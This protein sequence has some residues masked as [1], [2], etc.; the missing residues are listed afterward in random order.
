MHHAELEAVLFLAGDQGI[1]EKNLQDLLDLSSETL[2]TTV[3]DYQ[4]YLQ[5]DDQRGLQLIKVNQ[6]YK[7]VTKPNMAS[8]LKKYYKKDMQVH[9]SQAALEVLAIICYQQPITRVEIDEIR[10][11]ASQAAIQTLNARGLIA[12]N[13]KKDVPGRPKLFVTTDYFLQYFGFESLDEMPRIE[14]FKTESLIDTSI[15]NQEEV[16]EL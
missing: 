6:T 14:E 3:Q 15:I 5:Q 13:G 2:E 12:E 4:N 16:N 9:L 7:L 1:D 10:G 11:V 8:V